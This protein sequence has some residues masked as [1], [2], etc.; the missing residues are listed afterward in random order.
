MKY[1]LLIILCSI[2]SEVCLPPL[3]GGFYD[4][5]HNCAKNGYQKSVEIIN[6]IDPDLFNEYKYTIK[7]QCGELEDDHL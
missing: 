1:V 5:W 7:F 6:N 2:K 4:T 3:E